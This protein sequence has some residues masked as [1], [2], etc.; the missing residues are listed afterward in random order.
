MS[1][2]RPNMKIVIFLII[3]S[4]S[5]SGC[6]NS[7]LITINQF[8]NEFK[9][10]CKS[11]IALHSISSDK[12]EKSCECMIE[13]A[14]KRWHTIDSLNKSLIEEDRAPRGVLD[15]YQGAARI[16]YRACSLTHPSSGTASP[17]LMSNVSRHTG[18]AA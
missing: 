17:P 8:Q 16:T 3:L 2:G 15:Y 18:N 1:N 13:L 4:I 9:G 7:A 11:S 5:L 6:E 12:V 14:E 10:R